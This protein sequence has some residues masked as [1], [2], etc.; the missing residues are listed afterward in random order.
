MQVAHA[1]GTGRCGG[2]RNVSQP[3]QNR[4]RGF[5]KLLRAAGNVMRV[6]YLWNFLL[7]IVEPC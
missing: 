3:Q 7:N 5:I 4:A 2:Q 1:G 6:V